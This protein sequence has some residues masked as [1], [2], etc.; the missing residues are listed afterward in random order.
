MR[1]VAL[2]FLV[3]A[4]ALQT[5][6]TKAAPLELTTNSRH[7]SLEGRLEH[8]ADASGELGFEAVQQQNFVRLPL[9]RS[10]GYDTA[11]HWY[12]F[13]LT[14]A[15]NAPSLWILTIGIVILDEVDV[16]VEEAD[17]RFQTFA[18][19]DHR[20]YAGRPL[21]TRAFAVPV[22]VS[23]R[24]RIYL[25]V[26]S[27]SSI[28][29]ATELW[30]PQ[31]FVAVET[32]TNFH[33]G[34]YFGALLITALLYAVLGAWSRDTI[35]ATYAGYVASLIPLHMGLKGYLPVVF[36][37]DIPWFNDALWRISFL[38]GTVFIVLMWN[39]LMELKQNFP[40]IHRLYQ[41]IIAFNVALI[42]FVAT[43]V[44]LAVSP[45]LNPFM[46]ALAVLTMSLASVLWWRSRRIELLVYFVAFLIPA[47]GGAIQAL[48]AMGGVPNNALTTHAYQVAS[49]IHVA[50]MSLGLALRLRKMHR[51]KSVAEQEV[52]VTTQ[53]A[54]EQRRFVAMLSH[55]FR[56]P[57]AAIDRSA[58]MIQI[59]TP[60]LASSEAKRL[61][62][63]RANA[64]T[65]S[66]FVDNFLM[67][68][69]L[70]HGALA[71]SRE[72]ITLRPLLEAAIRMQGDNAGE[73][74]HLTV[75]PDDASF[76]LDPTL[77]GVAV[78]NLLSNA[79]RYSPPDSPVEIAAIKE[80]EELR[81]RVTDHGPGMS[82]DELAMLGAPYYRA[83][84]SLGKKGSGLGYHFTRRIIEAHGGELHAYS[85]PGS[86]T[87]VEIFLSLGNR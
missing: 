37:S 23:D 33:Q 52:A 84:S 54:E 15:A 12:R 58:Q 63:I 85:C 59:K 48:L 77:I 47:V 19:G 64:A 80:D 38:T 29:V 14:R 53:R 45:W 69:A 51:D 49:L 17:G 34:L 67:T 1:F 31:A 32:Q 60:E 18:L 56:N 11:T 28:N 26:R 78:G 35:L 57:L 72:S 66:G 40:R 9:F 61:E 79:L 3:L 39:R 46:I 83:S 81:I 7:V 76:D 55:E 65:L 68:E 75:M 8:F 20:P 21:Q 27:T 86:G 30:Q 25:R 70:D 4:T 71:L 24:T 44:Y 16:W 62:Q 74:I 73:R 50:V 87:A 22:E 13:D 10:Q 5:A 41:T 2:L 82:E 42:P 43:P 6:T 36:A